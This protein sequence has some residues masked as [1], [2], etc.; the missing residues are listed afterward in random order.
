MKLSNSDKARVD[1]EKITEYL[2]YA[3]HPD[4]CSKA[5]F[6]AQYGFALERWKILAESLRKQGITH[7]VVKTMESTYGTRYSV[8]G[9]LE[10]PDG[11]N[12]YVRTVWIIEKLSA[13][14]RLI[15]AHPILGGNHD[16]RT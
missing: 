16:K 12:P 11:R 2:L 6:F 5:A 1:R 13:T 8:D 4:G 9:P 14:P 7:P 15:T 3:S 10:T